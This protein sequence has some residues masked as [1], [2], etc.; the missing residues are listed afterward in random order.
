MDNNKETREFPIKPL[1]ARQ[2]LDFFPLSISEEEKEELAAE[3]EQN[4]ADHQIVT[5]DEKRFREI[6][7][8]AGREG[9]EE[10]LH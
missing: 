7:E 9:T 8:S 3:M 4:Y 1:S 2:F 5:K 6:L 10:F